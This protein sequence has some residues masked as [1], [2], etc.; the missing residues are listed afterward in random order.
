MRT[1]INLM[2]ES[3]GN[4]PDNI[5]MWEKTG[6]KYVGTS[7][8][9]TRR[10]VHAFSAGLMQLGLKPGE[11]VTLLS[12]G[13]ND[14]VISEL[15]VLYNGAI[16]VPISV[17]LK[18]GDEISFR[19]KH[20]GSRFAIASRN[21]IQKIID[22]AGDIPSLEHIICLDR[23]ETEDKRILFAEDLLQ[24]GKT[25][26][27]SHG[28]EFRKRFQSVSE[29]D[30]ANI[31]Y[32][33]GTTADPK[34]IILSHRNYTANVE[35]SISLH[36]IPEHFKT[37]VIIPWDHSFGHTCALY[38]IMKYGAS[39]ASVEIGKT[40]LETLKN[41]PKNI[42][43]IKPDFMLSVPAL[44]K[45]FKK[46]IEKGI[47]EKGPFVQGLFKHAMK[48]AYAYNGNGWNRGK[49]LRLLLYPLVKLYDLILFKK[50]RQGLGGN[51]KFFVGGGALL[52]IELQRFF[53]AVGMPMYQGYGLSEASPVISSNS[54]KYA[55]MGSSGVIA[56]GIK[57]RICDDDDRELP[58]GI[59]GEILVQGENVMKGYWKNET[60]TAETLRNGWL[61]TGDLGYL[62]KDGFL[63]V[64]GRSK[65]LLIAD[66][67]EK[68]SPEGIEEAFAENSPFIDQC[69][70]YNNQMPYSVCLIVPN[71]EAL[72]KLSKSL[73][74]DSG[75]AELLEKILSELN[76][77][78]TRGDLEEMFPQ[79]WLPAAIGILDEGFSLDNE[80][81]NST[82]KIVRPKI[83]EKY[84]SFLE[85]LYT[86]EAKDI[87][88]E[89]NIAAI[90][91]LLS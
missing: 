64:L 44:A 40:P 28:E 86:P 83:T 20:S 58:Q 36:S 35:Q 2:E 77:Y 7:Y 17:N 42:Q 41:V 51:L 53:F 39:V 15:G 34:G 3:A 84:A 1:L 27:A 49:G 81:M 16:N 23:I 26:L 80:L 85:Y 18:A 14:W 54:S 33:S 31:C 9:D 52:D 10:R 87:S 5:Y 57:I 25:F 11:R 70:M 67:G 69:M 79:R 30:Y 13:R 60:A 50:V 75:P 21:H 88:N 43:E 22:V 62:D 74:E 76:R 61:H 73:G 68:F 6:E 65:S 56:K 32:T 89:K 90:R 47:Q 12:E 38:S 72:K 29:D 46:N 19:L 63:Y 24:A 37:Y 66:D 78:R 48:L 8:Q 82:M 55:K 91:K 71:K 45:N 59:K 4:F